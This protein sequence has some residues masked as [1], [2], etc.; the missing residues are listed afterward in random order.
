MSF[1][2]F[3]RP[4]L[5]RASPWLIR[6]RIAPTISATMKDR[7]ETPSDTQQRQI[8]TRCDIRRCWQALMSELCANQRRQLRERRDLAVRLPRQALRSLAV[9][10][11]PRDAHAEGRS[12]ISVPRIGGLE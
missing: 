9:A 7:R 5:N 2:Q 12:G 10:V 1:V 3:S 6:L 8:V 4:S 11:A